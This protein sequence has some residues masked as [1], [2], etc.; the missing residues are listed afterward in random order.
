MPQP[1]SPSILSTT[2]GDVG[3]RWLRLGIAVGLVAFT[4]LVILPRLADVP[5]VKRHIETM[6]D[7]GIDPSAMFYSELEPH[8]FLDQPK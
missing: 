1:S 3:R 5:P 4:W 8:L 2:P 6:Q 7:A